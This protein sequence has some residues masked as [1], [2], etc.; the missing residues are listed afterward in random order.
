LL[1]RKQKGKYKGRKPTLND[2]QIKLLKEKVSLGEKKT[3]VAR[4]FSIS[5]ETLYQYLT[6]RT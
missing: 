3:A 4:Y 2:E 1:Y 6:N 5:R